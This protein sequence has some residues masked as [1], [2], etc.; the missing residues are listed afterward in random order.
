MCP[1]W[2]IMQGE[3]QQFNALQERKHIKS[4]KNKDFFSYVRFL[5]Q[6][7]HNYTQKASLVKK[8]SS[9]ASSGSD[10]GFRVA[11]WFV[12]RGRRL[13]REQGWSQNLSKIKTWKT[14]DPRPEN[15]GEEETPFTVVC[16]ALGG[17]TSCL[18]W[19]IFAQNTF[20]ITWSSN[21]C[22]SSP[23]SR[24]FRTRHPCH[25]AQVLHYTGSESC[26]THAVNIWLTCPPQRIHWCCLLVNCHLH[27]I[28]L[29]DLYNP[30]CHYSAYTTE[31]S[32]WQRNTHKTLWEIQNGFILFVSF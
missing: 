20:L 15:S 6:S 11:P 32:K 23:P 19:T 5:P 26:T 10:C 2:G 16:A 21:N 13:T 31:A 25:L 4:A 8:Q 3:R 17:P 29:V 18:T 22:V 30:V 27:V 9:R 1:P 7:L 12:Q 24:T 28:Q 14:V